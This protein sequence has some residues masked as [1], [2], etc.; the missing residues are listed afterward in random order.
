MSTASKLMCC[1]PCSRA[2]CAR[3]STGLGKISHRGTELT[4][5]RSG[6]RNRRASTFDRKVPDSGKVLGDCEQH[7]QETDGQAGLGRKPAIRLLSKQAALVNGVSARDRKRGCAEFHPP[8]KRLALP[9][10]S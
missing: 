6:L 1:I 3:F 9:G 10:P 5:A 2:R 8:A 4:F 7:E